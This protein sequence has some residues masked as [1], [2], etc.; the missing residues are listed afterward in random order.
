MHVCSDS[1]TDH[2]HGPVYRSA[3]M[4]SSPGGASLS[5]ASHDPSLKYGTT[6]KFLCYC[7]RL[8]AGASVVRTAGSVP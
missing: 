2:D 8:R 3:A 5:I 1:S 4:R 7:G 6:K